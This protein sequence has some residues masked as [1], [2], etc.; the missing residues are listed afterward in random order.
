MSGSRKGKKLQSEINL[1]IKRV[2][3]GVDKFND[4]YDLIHE[5]DSH[6]KQNA[7]ALKREI[8]KLQKHRDQLKTWIAAADVRDTS[9]LLSHRKLIESVCHYTNG[10]N[11]ANGALQDLRA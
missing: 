9:T 8:K 1:T 2:K 3:E 10:S 7:D 11:T 6:S 4:L 5:G